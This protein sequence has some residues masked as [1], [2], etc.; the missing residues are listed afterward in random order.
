M[1][2]TSRRNRKSTIYLLIKSK[3]NITK[4][5]QKG[6]EYTAHVLSRKSLK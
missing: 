3:K 4:K 5:N 6:S 2:K 1:R